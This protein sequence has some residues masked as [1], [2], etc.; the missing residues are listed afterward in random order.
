MLKIIWKSADPHLL[1]LPGFLGQRL[2]I[3]LGES[4]NDMK[5]SLKVFSFKKYKNTTITLFSKEFICIEQFS[6]SLKRA[7]LVISTHGRSLAN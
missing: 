6:V 4:K 5:I 1:V 3:N 2:L 7:L